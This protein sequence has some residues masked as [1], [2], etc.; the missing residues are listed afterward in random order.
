MEDI[1][2]NETCACTIK[3]QDKN[4][5]PQNTRT[6]AIWLVSGIVLKYKI[7]QNAV[8]KGTRRS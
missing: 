8:I 4:E 6:P 7:R 3:K 1:Q 5:S 2:K